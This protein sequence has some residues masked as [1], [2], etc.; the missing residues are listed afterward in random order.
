MLREQS[1]SF[2]GWAVV[3]SILSTLGVASALS[4]TR[5]DTACV[6]VC[7][8]E[9][10]VKVPGYWCRSIA[11]PGD[12]YCPVPPKTHGVL[13]A[14]RGP[15]RRCTGRRTRR[16]MPPDLPRP[17]WSTIYLSTGRFSRFVF[18]HGNR[19]VEWAWLRS[20]LVELPCKTGKT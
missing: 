6:C 10:R 1:T 5:R 2:Y 19:L 14:P 15:S 8:A 9:T 18:R 11:G 13:R 4:V 12:H 20:T 17:L 16:G 3:L 7:D